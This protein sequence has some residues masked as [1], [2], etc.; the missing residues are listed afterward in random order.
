MFVLSYFFIASKTA[1]DKV[2]DWSE[3][4]GFSCI[5][6]LTR[7]SIAIVLKIAI[8]FSIII[9][10]TSESYKITVLFYNII[11][12]NSSPSYLSQQAEHSIPPP[13]PQGKK[14]QKKPNKQTKKNK[15]KKQKLSSRSKL[16]RKTKQKQEPMINQT[17]RRS[18]K[19]LLEVP[20][21]NRKEIYREGLFFYQIIRAFL[22]TVDFYLKFLKTF[23]GK[24]FIDADSEMWNKLP[25]HI[26]FA[27][28]LDRYTIWL[29][30]S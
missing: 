21:H 7:L 28:H 13:P 8:L 12:G 20:Q 19:I 15:K 25:E 26:R 30:N 29:K 22:G 10:G 4:K 1:T 16:P 24:F 2:P 3:R 11:D 17:S 5:I 18:P 23:W 14:Q 6:I 27:Q 9:M